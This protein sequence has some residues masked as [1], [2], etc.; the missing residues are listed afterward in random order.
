MLKIAQMDFSRMFL[1]PLGQHV[2]KQLLACFFFFY[3]SPPETKSRSKHVLTNK[4]I[5][6]QNLRW[7]CKALLIHIC[8][9]IRYLYKQYTLLTDCLEALQFQTSPHPSS[10]EAICLL[11]HKLK[12]NVLIYTYSQ[13]LLHLLFGLSRSCYLTLA[14]EFK[15]ATH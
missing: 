7:C 11:W 14:L 10:V 4:L 8:V 3:C 2:L 5:Y 12:C 13:H 15:Q 9:C 6:L 1:Q